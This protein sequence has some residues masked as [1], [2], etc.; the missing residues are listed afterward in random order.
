MLS[1]L[2]AVLAV[3]LICVFLFSRGLPSIARIGIFNFIGGT[4][5]RPTNTNPEFGILPMILGSI[6]VTAGAIFIGVPIGILTAVFMARIC[7][8]PLYRVLKPL[9]SLLAGIPSIVYGF[10]G[11]MVIVP[12]LENFFDLTSGRTMLAASIILGIMILPTVI[13]ISETSIR[14]VPKELYEGAVALGASHERALFR[15]ILPAAKSGVL[16]AVVLGIGR[17]IGETMAVNMVAGNQALIRMPW[18][19]M[20]G[21]RTLTSNIV[22]EMGYAEPLHLEALIATGVVLFVFIILI[23]LLFSVVTKKSERVKSKSSKTDKKSPAGMIVA[24]LAAAVIGVIVV[25]NFGI[26]PDVER[27]DATI[28]GV[29]VGGETVQGEITEGTIRNGL[30]INIT[31][32]GELYRMREIDGIILDGEI[33]DIVVVYGEEFTAEIVGNEIRSVAVPGENIAAII[34]AIAGIIIVLLLSIFAGKS[35][36][37]PDWLLKWL[38]WLASAATVMAMGFIVGYILIRGIPHLSPELFSWSWNMDNQSMLPSILNTAVLVVLTLA[39]AV[40]FGIFSAIF[41]VEY[42]KRGSKLVK[43]IRMVTETLAGIPSIVYGLFGFIFFVRF[44]GWGFSALAGAFTLA[45]MVLPIVMRTTEESLKSVPDP[46]REGSFG[47]G[48][49]RLRTVF[50]IVLPSAMPGILAGVILAVGRI[51]GETAAL[52]FT[53]GTIA[54]VMQTPMSSARTLSVHM[55]MLSSEGTYRDQAHATAVVL[56]FLVIAINAVSSIIAKRVT[57]DK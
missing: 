20:E 36:S 41:L 51:V 10:F 44:L 43:L 31:V 22:L 25:P 26:V 39:I 16:A 35:F 9:I 13:T 1:A 49:G 48:A 8:K 18:E 5:W 47:L 27:T 19:F 42:A 6:Y 52:M 12:W 30:I 38:T 7:P 17:A 21:I 32:D 50:R 3:G 34:G 4:E 33:V 53:A 57:R 56:L 23:N 54:N 29:V 40:P 11:L 28:E 24:M 46:F 37:M 45:I 55:F 15:V 2:T 14:A